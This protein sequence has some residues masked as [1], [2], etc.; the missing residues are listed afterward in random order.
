[1]L[2]KKA[3]SIEK[4][5]SK[6]CIVFEYPSENKE[7]SVAI[8]VING[9]YPDKGRVFNAKCAQA[10]YVISGSGI[11]Y[12]EKGNFKIAKGDVYFFEKKETYFVEGKKLSLH[13]SN[14]PS[15]YP[16]QYKNIK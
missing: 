14:S 12:S 5:N 4:S 15:W 16:E 3:D 1:M 13:I 11:I 2:I 8:A 10:Y 7:I 6:Q 9:R